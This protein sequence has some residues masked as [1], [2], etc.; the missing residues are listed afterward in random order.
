[1][2]SPLA[3]V[4]PRQVPEIAFLCQAQCTG[5]SRM[6]E[7][8]VMRRRVRRMLEC[9]ASGVIHT[10]IFTKIEHLLGLYERRNTPPCRRTPG[11]F[12]QPSRL[13]EYL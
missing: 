4:R 7:V 1:M 8:E 10:L 11:N 6:G 5:P 9:A 3:T 12:A 13:A 2:P